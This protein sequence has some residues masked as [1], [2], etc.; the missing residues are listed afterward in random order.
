MDCRTGFPMDYR[1]GDQNEPLFQ[2]CFQR[3]FLNTTVFLCL[4][5]LFSHSLV[6]LP[7]LGARKPAFNWL[8]SNIFRIWACRRCIK[9]VKSKSG[10]WQIWGFTT[11]GGW[12]ISPNGWFIMA[13]PIRIDDFRGTHIL[14]NLQIYPWGRGP[15][16]GFQVTWNRIKISLWLGIHDPLVHF[17]PIFGWMSRCQWWFL[18]LPHFLFQILSGS[19]HTRTLLFQHW[20]HHCQ[21]SFRSRSS[22]YHPKMENS[23][24][25]PGL[26]NFK[27]LHNYG[28]SHHFQWENPL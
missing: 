14:G 10:A 6:L 3:L 20:Y 2:S 18:G 17:A 11:N 13:N 4:S 21:K 16:H 22:S 8:M 28:K 15:C 24:H 9:G 1:T 23:P 19:S 5:S 26:V 25:L 27:R 7:Y 12:W